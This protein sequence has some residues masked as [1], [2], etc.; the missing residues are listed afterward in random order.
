MSSLAAMK[1]E[2]H[3]RLWSA[4]ERW[5]RLQAAGTT[6]EPAHERI[7]PAI[8]QRA[9]DRLRVLDERFEVAT[10]L[11]RGYHLASEL[12]SRCGLRAFEATERLTPD[13]LAGGDVVGKGGRERGLP[14]PQDAEIG[15]EEVAHQD[16]GVREP[17]L[18]SQINRG[19]I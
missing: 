3:Q 18:L 7:T 2:L 17:Q 16:L 11:P 4:Q 1:E 12:Q 15:A 8:A 5:F 14:I 19:P 13:R 10:G 9:L 6:A